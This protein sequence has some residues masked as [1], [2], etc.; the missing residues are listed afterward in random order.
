MLAYGFAAEII[1][2]L[3]R[4]GLATAVSETVRAGD[5]TIKEARIKITDAG[6]RALEG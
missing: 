1:V 2:S 3:V 5:R 6:L 4:D